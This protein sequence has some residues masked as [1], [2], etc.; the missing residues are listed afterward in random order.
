MKFVL[1]GAINNIPA[2]VQVMAWRLAGQWWLVYWRIYVSLN[3]NE[4]NQTQGHVKSITRTCI[5]YS[6]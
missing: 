5:Q 3:L 2:L 6:V 1:N 4:L